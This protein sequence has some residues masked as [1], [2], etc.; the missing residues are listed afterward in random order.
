MNSLIK[1]YTVARL[2]EPV[3]KSGSDA[4][5]RYRSFIVL[6]QCHHWLTCYLIQA[7]QRCWEAC[8]FRGQELLSP[9][10]ICYAFDKGQFGKLVVFSELVAFF[11]GSEATLRANSELVLRHVK[12]SFFDTCFQVG[13]R[14]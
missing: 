6:T 4:K 9:N 12:L 8:Y 7:P 10:A 3:I 5:R 14:F 11:G 13:F 1:L 2:R